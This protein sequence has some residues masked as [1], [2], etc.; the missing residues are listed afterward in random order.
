MRVM[1]VKI[2]LPFSSLLRRAF[3][4][5]LSTN[6]GLLSVCYTVCPDILYTLRAFY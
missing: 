1:Y 5:Y 4:L 2:K 3:I 6:G